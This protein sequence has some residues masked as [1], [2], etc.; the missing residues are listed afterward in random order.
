MKCTLTISNLLL[1]PPIS[2]ED[3][4][5]FNDQIDE[6]CGPF[7]VRDVEMRASEALYFVE[8]ETYR[9]YLAEFAAIDGAAL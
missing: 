3:N 4:Q 1:S 5:A 9:I 2:F 8:P 7:S 6:E